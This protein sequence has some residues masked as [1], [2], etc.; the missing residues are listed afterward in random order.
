VLHLNAVKHNSS[1]Y[2]ATE[3]FI[4]E[5]AGQ[6]IVLTAFAE[7]RKEYDLAPSPVAHL[8]YASALTAAQ[9][10]LVFGFVFT[11]LAKGLS[12]L[13]EFLHNQSLVD[14]VGSERTKRAL[15]DLSRLPPGSHL[16]DSTTYA[17][18]QR[19][20]RCVRMK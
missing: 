14:I 16:P 1:L 2:A 11:D 20:L 7:L 12:S 13:D 8:P 18:L 4:C 15:W 6:T 19:T 5:L 10:D 9:H 3:R 17:W